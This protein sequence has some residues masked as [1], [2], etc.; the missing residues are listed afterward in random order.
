[1]HRVPPAATPPGVAWRLTAPSTPADAARCAAG[2]RRDRAHGLEVGVAAQ[3]PRVP[4]AL[5]RGCE[6]CGV[7][8]ALVKWSACAA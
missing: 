1:M 3:A 2:N 8:R 7:N 4:G 5:G 6:P